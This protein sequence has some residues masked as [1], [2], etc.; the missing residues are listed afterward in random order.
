ML[1]TFHLLCLPLP[2][3]CLSG[4]PC[5]CL[6]ILSVSLAVKMSLD[7]KLFQ[8]LYWQAESDI[9]GFICSDFAFPTKLHI[10]VISVKALLKILDRNGKLCSEIHDT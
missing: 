1:I 6:C 5:Y 9:K 10:W 2:D 3:P 8:V 7:A 4:F